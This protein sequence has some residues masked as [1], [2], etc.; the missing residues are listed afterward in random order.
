MV[1]ENKRD[2]GLILNK[3]E[4]PLQIGYVRLPD[5][6][7][8]CLNGAVDEITIIRAVAS[9]EDIKGLAAMKNRIKCVPDLP[10]YFISP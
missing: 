4:N 5:G 1:Q 3:S 9:S 7:E 6:R 10:K 2:S 8:E